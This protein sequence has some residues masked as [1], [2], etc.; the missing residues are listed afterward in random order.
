ME[1][2]ERPNLLSFFSSKVSSNQLYVKIFLQHTQLKAL[3]KHSFE[4][5]QRE[6]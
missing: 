5:V 3:H 4:I 2:P 6:M 1:K